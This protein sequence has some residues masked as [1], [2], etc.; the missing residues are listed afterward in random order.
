MSDPGSS[1]GPEGDLAL[2]FPDCPVLAA[3]LLLF[4]L[5]RTGFSRCRAV[6]A[7][8]GIILTAVR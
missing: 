6:A 7:H 4:R 1:C 2:F 8:G 3:P 5:K